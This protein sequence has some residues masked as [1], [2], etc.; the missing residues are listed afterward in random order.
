MQGRACAGPRGGRHAAPAACADRVAA[1][2]HQRPADRR[3][4]R[5]QVK[6]A[7]RAMGFP[8]RKAEVRELLRDAGLDAAAPLGRGAFAEVCAAKLLERRPEDDAARAF[9]LFDVSGLGR[10]GRDELRAVARQ[11]GVDVAP[12]ELDAMVAEFDTDGDG[13]ISPSEFDAV[14]RALD[15]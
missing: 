7:L 1:S 6:V 10:L 4:H 11:L 5:G 13:F 8:V 14:M 3:A 2:Q 9:R 15:E 12:E